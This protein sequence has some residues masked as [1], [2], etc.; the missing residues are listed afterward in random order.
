MLYSQAVP[1]SSL[2]IQE[3]V[4]LAPYTTLQ[5]G[6]A[7][8]YF[9]E[10]VNE[11]QVEEA[12][13]FAR[14]QNLPLFVLGGGSNLLVSDAGFDGVVLHIAIHGIKEHRESNVVLLEVGAGENWNAVVLYAVERGY[15]GVE[16][17]AG[18]PGNA[19]GTPVQNVGAYG[20]EIAETIA[21]VRAYDLESGGFVEF[22][23]AECHFGYR[24]SLFNTEA[25]GRYIITKVVYQLQ[26]EGE[27]ALR[28]ADLQ[29]HFKDKLDAGA[30]PSLRQ[31]YDAVRS[32]R[33]QKG[34]L[35]G[36]GGSDGRSAG[37][38][39]KNP[40]VP[41]SV[42]EKIAG[43]LSID[44]NG[45]PHWPTTEGQI[46]LSAAWLIE[47]AGFARGFALGSAGISSRHTLALINRGNATAAE[48]FALRDAI[49]DKVKVLF[50]VQLEQEPVQLG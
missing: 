7:V 30:Q 36:Q 17:L 23:S 42:L 40:V 27:P 9:L 16:C 31:V 46:K 25:C 26:P 19:G 35:A 5:V 38:F 32:I 8:R 11:A 15:A 18:I 13:A 6:G 20:Q 34:M 44:T 10:V 2:K 45:I 33:E 49:Q 1:L 48:I 4:L 21:G 24:R 47:K 41:H 22:D 43:T 3:Q 28:Y 37:S 12:V 14:E 50:G 39:F 29:R